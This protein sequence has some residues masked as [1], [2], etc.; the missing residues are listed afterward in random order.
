M[1]LKEEMPSGWPDFL[2]FAS[3]GLRVGFA[4]PVVA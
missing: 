4:T 1:K 3:S 2:L